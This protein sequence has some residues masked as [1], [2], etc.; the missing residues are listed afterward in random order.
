MSIG[1]THAYFQWM[2]VADV[3]SGTVAAGNISITSDGTASAPTA[4]NTFEY[5]ASGGNRSLSCRYKVPTGYTFYMLSWIGH[6][7]G[8]TMD[9]RLRGN[10]FADDRTISNAAQHFQAIAFI[11]AGATHNEDMHYLKFPAGCVIKV[12]AIPGNAPAGNRLDARFDGLLV[13]D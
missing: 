2:E 9:T 3:G 10:V 11:A 5:I 1:A 12:S 7:I 8:T 6:A 4:A 13:A